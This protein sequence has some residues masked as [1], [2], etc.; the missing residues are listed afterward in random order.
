MKTLP[1]PVTTLSRA[2]SAYN[3]LM[4]DD[5]PIDFAKV[6]ELVQA[7]GAVVRASDKALDARYF[8]NNNRRTART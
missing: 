8:E 7:C 2:R 4:Q 5:L 1:I 3:A 6:S